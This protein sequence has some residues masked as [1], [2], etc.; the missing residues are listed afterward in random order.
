MTEKGVNKVCALCQEAGA[1]TD[2][3]TAFCGI[4][5]RNEHG[6]GLHASQG[7]VFLPGQE[8][9]CLIQSALTVTEGVS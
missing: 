5:L 9:T 6:G 4:M 1:M 7:Q 3:L 8:G 2:M